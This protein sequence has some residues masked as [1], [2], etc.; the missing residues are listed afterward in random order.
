VA[1]IWCRFLGC[2]RITPNQGFFELGGDSML[3]LHLTFALSQ[4]LGVELSPLVLFEAQT[5]RELAVRIDAMV[6]Q[7]DGDEHKKHETSDA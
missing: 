7:A 1:E 2:D 3:A 4:S 5:V 6:G